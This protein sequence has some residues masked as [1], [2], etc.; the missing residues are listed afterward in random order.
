MVVKGPDA[1][2]TDPDPDD[3]AGARDAEGP[4]TDSPGPEVIVK[5]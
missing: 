3:R 2:V 5:S 1:G 4:Q